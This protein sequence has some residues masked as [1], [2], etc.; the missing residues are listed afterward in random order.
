[1]GTVAK[2]RRLLP[3]D[4]TKKTWPKS[5]TD[6]HKGKILIRYTKEMY[7]FVWMDRKPVRILS[8]FSSPEIETFPHRCVSNLIMRKPK[9]IREYNHVM[10]GV[11]G[12]DQKRHVKTVTRSQQKNPYKKVNI[13]HL[14]NSYLHTLW[15]YLW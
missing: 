6:I 11:D 3:K 5:K 1:L 9:A 4:I 13:L 2:G 8:T 7:I 12:A 10:P 14:S 15:T